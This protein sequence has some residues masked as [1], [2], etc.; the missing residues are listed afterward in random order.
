VALAVKN[1]MPHVRRAI[2]SLQRQTYRNFELIVHDGASTDDSVTFIR[3][4]KDIPRIDIER[5]PDRSIADGYDLAYRRCR[6]EVVHTLGSDEILEPQALET[7]AK[8]HRE[9]PDAVMVYG[10]YNLIDAA[11]R[12][13]STVRPRPFDLLQYLKLKMSPATGPAFLNR[14]LIGAELYQD[15]SLLA[16]GDRE[17]YVRL[18]LKFGEER[19]VKKS[20]LMI[21]LRSDPVSMSFRPDDYN[22]FIETGVKVIENI[23]AEPLLSRLR[24]YLVE[25]GVAS[26]DAPAGGPLSAGEQALKQ[27]FLF[28]NYAHQAELVY[29]LAGDCEQYRRYI[30]TAARFNPEPERLAALLRN[31]S[32]LE[33]DPATK[34]V[35]IKRPVPAVP[36]PGATRS[37]GA[38]SASRT[39]VL[40]HWAALGARRRRRFNSIDVY[41][42]PNHWSYAAI[43]PI[44]QHKIARGHLWHWVE[45]RLAVLEGAVGIALYDLTTDAVERH[46]IVT[47]D[48]VSP[49]H[50][51]INDFGRI[52]SV[53]IRNGPLD[54]VSRVRIW[55]AAVVSV[56]RN[57]TL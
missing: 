2:E 32:A 24:R 4:A 42:P 40:P 20:S 17:L 10:D 29:G 43:L 41:T 36:P 18:A 47:S 33:L 12:I 14:R 26:A 5:A 50:I 3:T 6:G 1:G 11:E 39:K 38:L 37:S 19:F 30:M 25:K 15:G 51:P 44:D 27:E 49:I 52:D 56:P 46:V 9:H 23:F 45:L 22:K 35:R 31:T 21:N 34:V 54:G 57:D 7:F 28:H 13:V 48:A 53:L 16:A 55:R 8:W